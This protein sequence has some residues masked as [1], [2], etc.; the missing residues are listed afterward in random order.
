ML[1][2]VIIQPVPPATVKCWYGATFN[3]MC[4]NVCVGLAF[5]SPYP[6]LRLFHHW[7]FCCF[8]HLLTA[9][10]FSAYRL[11]QSQQVEEG[12]ILK[13]VEIHSVGPVRC[14]ACNDHTTTTA[15]RSAQAHIYMFNSRTNLPISRLPVSKAWSQKEKMY[16]DYG[17]ATSLPR[18]NSGGVGIYPWVRQFPSVCGKISDINLLPTSMQSQ[19]RLGFN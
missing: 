1:R 18:L 11:S 9:V 10:P 7:C 13:S 5:F 12:Q 6:L 4:M 3:R 19:Y 14:A 8:W 16:K 17:S 15:P 2:A